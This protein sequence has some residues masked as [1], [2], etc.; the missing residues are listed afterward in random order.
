MNIICITSKDFIS[1]FSVASAGLY[2]VYNRYKIY[3]KKPL[4]FPAF[5]LA[6]DYMAF[7]FLIL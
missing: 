7:S 5:D 4:I 6:Y 3:Y 1:I 2:D